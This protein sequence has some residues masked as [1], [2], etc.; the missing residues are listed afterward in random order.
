[1][2][3][4]I[5]GSGITVWMDGSLDYSWANPHGVATDTSPQASAMVGGA[6]WWGDSDGW[7]GRIGE[8]IVLSGNVSTGDMQTVD[9]Y[10]LREW[11]IPG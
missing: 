9:A 4:E 11:D 6:P 7:V 3:A 8:I 2:T 5:T 10:L 1:V